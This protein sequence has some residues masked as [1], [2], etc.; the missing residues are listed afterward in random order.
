MIAE[1]QFR[2]GYFGDV[3]R[4]QAGAIFERVVATGSWFCARSA[5][6]GPESCRPIVFWVRRCDA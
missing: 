5:A 4:E 3:R 2:I 1:E 6:I